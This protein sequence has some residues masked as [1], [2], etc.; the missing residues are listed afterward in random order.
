MDLKSVTIPHSVSSIGECAF[1]DC[2][3]ISADLSGTA[4]T[5]L[6]VR[7]FS[8]CDE[9]TTVDL[10]NSSITSIEA[11]AFSDCVR[12]ENITLPSTLEKIGEY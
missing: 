8:A 10:S 1:R 9:L 4:V 12:L 2:E 11:G 5:T 7:I 6:P 3:L